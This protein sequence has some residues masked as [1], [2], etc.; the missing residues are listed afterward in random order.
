MTIS[1]KWMNCLRTAFLVS[2]ISLVFTGC[3]SQATAPSSDKTVQDNKSTEAASG[4]V[5]SKLKLADALTHE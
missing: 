2:A 4:T 3:Q 5:T 1:S